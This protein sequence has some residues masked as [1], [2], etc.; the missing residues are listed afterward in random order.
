MPR[1]AR[2]FATGLILVVGACSA[3]APEPSPPPPV[4]A[5]RPAPTA[6]PS[7]AIPQYDSWMDVPATAGDWRYRQAA[8]GGVAEFVGQGG[9]RLFELACTADRQVRLAAIGAAPAAAT[10]QIRTEALSGAVT[11]APGNGAVTATLA[12]RDPLLAAM[13]FSKGRFAVEVPSLQSLYLPAWPEVT[14]VIEDCL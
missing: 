5:P 9:N 14:R 11:A 13:A 6:P 4:A 1:L 12:P 2:I 10:M 3:P 7:V 8:R